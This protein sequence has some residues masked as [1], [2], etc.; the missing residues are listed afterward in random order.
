MVEPNL[1]SPLNADVATLYSSD[2]D[3]FAKCA[4]EMT[5]QHAKGK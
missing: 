2:K 4:R 3:A 5:A 1:A